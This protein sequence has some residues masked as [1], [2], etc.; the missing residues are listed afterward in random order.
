MALYH[1]GPLCP[2]IEYAIRISKWTLLVKKYQA[3]ILNL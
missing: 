3:K 1:M 2:I